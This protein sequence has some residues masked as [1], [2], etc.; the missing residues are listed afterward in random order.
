M[1]LVTVGHHP[2]LTVEEVMKVFINHFAGKYVV[3]M[4]RLGWAK[5]IVVKKSIWIGVN[6]RLRQR[7]DET[8]FVFVFFA[9][10]RVIRSVLGS[11]WAYVFHRSECQAMENEVG[12]FIKSAVEFK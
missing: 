6:I 3:Y 1:T 7:K 8:S 10:S 5:S 9:P 11:S 4:Y 12:A 2:E